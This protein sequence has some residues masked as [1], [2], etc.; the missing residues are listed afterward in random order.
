MG[1]HPFRPERF[2][3][4]IEA[5]ILSIALPAPSVK[6]RAVTDAAPTLRLARIIGQIRSV[7]AIP[8]T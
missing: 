2:F 3:G 1:G 4:A 6:R 7:R 8:A 5:R